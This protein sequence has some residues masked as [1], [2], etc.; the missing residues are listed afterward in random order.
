MTT[1]ELNRAERILNG[2]KPKESFDVIHHRR[3]KRQVR[4]AK[5]GESSDV[6]HTAI[7]RNVTACLQKFPPT[8]K[9][10]TPKPVARKQAKPAPKPVSLLDKYQNA[11]VQEL[12]TLKRTDPQTFAKLQSLADHV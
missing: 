10:S 9:A 2:L 8:P 6:L 4:Q 3:A 1:E 11:S 7:Q 5:A 12:A